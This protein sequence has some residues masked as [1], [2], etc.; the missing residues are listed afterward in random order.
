MTPPKKSP[1]QYL[2]TGFRDV[3]RFGDTTACTRCLDLLSDI[4]LFHAVK[5]GYMAAQK[6]ELTNPSQKEVTEPLPGH[7]TFGIGCRSRLASWPGPGL[8]R[9]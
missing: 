1:Q 2:A 6:R 5:L 9:G 3:D 7:L 4:P 8:C